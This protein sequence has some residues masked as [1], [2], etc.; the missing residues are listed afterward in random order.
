[1]QELPLPWAAY[2]RLQARSSRNFTIDSYSWG[3][4][5]EMNLF[6][7]DTCAY[8]SKEARGLKRLRAT[9][10]R[11]ERS[12]ESILNSHK[13][14]LVTKPTGTVLY[15]EA[16]QALAMIQAKVS[17]TQWNFLRAIG[18][19]EGYAGASSKYAISIGAARAQMF[20]FRQQ[21]A[22]LRPAA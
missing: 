7:T 15:L 6:V 13:A 8:T 20:R 10:S 3:I 9:T 16:R 4:E 21:F 12:R 18:E 5:E 11:R 22:N 1:M 17:P 14:E 19:G 2:A